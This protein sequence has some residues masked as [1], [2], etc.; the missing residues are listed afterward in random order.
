MNTRVL[1]CYT[2]DNPQDWDLHNRSL[3]FSYSGPV[4]PLH[5]KIG[6]GWCLVVNKFQKYK[7]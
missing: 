1:L 4:V 5:F 2:Y 7:I 6:Q 3:K